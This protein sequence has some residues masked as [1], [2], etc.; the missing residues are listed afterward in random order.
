VWIA[1]RVIPSRHGELLSVNGAELYFTSSVTRAEAEKLAEYLVRVG[2]FGGVR[3]RVQ[4]TRA[5]KIYQVRY[6]VR[7]GVESDSGLIQ[8]WQFAAAEMSREVFGGEPVEIHLCDRSLQ[9]LRVVMPT[10]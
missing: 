10:G 2:H 6:A 5:G 8:D 1:W 7:K 9:T 3:K 4:L